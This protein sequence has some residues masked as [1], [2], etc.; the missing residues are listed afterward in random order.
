MGRRKIEMKRIEDKSSRQVTFSKRRSGLIKKARELSILCDV[1]VA[2]LVFSHRGRLYEF[3]SGAS[4]SSS[5]S[6]ILRRYQDSTD[7]KASNVDD[8]TEDSPSTCIQVQ[9]CGE[10][11]KTV[12]RYAEGSG[13]ENLSLEDFMQL[14][15]QLNDALVQTRNRKAQLMLESVA[16]L[17]EKEKMLTQE[18]DQ[19]KDEVAKVKGNLNRGN[20]TDLELNGV[21]EEGALIQ[22]PEP[23]RTLPLLIEEGECPE[24]VKT[25]PLLW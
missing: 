4:S 25:L 6:Q 21:M 8:E 18:N 16:T 15:K 10:L 24:P 22:C 12:E 19:L 3:V 20:R 14:E 13:I 5:L 2:V 11:V 17:R 1:D 7:G 9:T 23:V